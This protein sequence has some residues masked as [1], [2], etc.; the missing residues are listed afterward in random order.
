MK[1][2]CII[3]FLLTLLGCKKSDD[4]TVAVAGGTNAAAFNTVIGANGR[5]WMDRNLGA[6]RVATSST[7]AESYGDLYQWGR[8][9]DGHQLRTSGTTNTL[10]NTDKTVNSLFILDN[11]RDP[12]DW[13][14]PQ[15][16]NLWQGVNGIN[17]PCPTGFRIPTYEEWET[18]RKSWNSNNLLGAYSS[19]LKLTAA[20]SRNGQTGTLLTT[21]QG[22]Y[23]SS[24]FQ[25]SS[26][27]STSNILGI[28]TGNS[29]FANGSRAS[30]ASCRCIKD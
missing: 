14:V 5:I 24:T 3:I 6:S 25:T 26:S 28:S 17:N 29:S 1:N 15:N 27:R 21:G 22:A 10:S 4:E 9:S 11:N 16:N 20:S 23:W 13:R 7:D 30:G 12:Y 19:P 2:L 18:E 8:G